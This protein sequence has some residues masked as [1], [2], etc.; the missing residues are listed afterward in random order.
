MLDLLIDSIEVVKDAFKPREKR[1]ERKRMRNAM[2]YWA[3]A[4]CV[5]IDPASMRGVVR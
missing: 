3:V 2:H 4:G 5:S 1:E